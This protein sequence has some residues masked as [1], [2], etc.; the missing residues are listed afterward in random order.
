MAPAAGAPGSE[1]GRDCVVHAEPGGAWSP[2]SGVYYNPNDK[3]FCGGGA[4]TAAGGSMLSLLVSVPLTT[5]TGRLVSGISLAMTFPACCWLVL[6]SGAKPGS[7]HG[8]CIA[9]SGAG[10]GDASLGGASPG[11]WH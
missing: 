7:S 4:Q 11:A 10:A 9:L 8:S 5:V 3:T 2:G 1:Q 6:R